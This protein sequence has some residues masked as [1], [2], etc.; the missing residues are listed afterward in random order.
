LF[1][2]RRK[3]KQQTQQLLVQAMFNS[4]YNT[5]SRGSCG[6]CMCLLA[7]EYCIVLGIFACATLEYGNRGSCIMLNVSTDTQE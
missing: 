3:S 2:R 5:S 4:E 7:S 1:D 6:S